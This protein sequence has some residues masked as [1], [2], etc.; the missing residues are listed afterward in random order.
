MEQAGVIPMVNRINQIVASTELACIFK[1]GERPS[2]LGEIDSFLNDPESLVLRISLQ[3][4]SYAFHTREIVANAVGR[5][6]LE[7]ARERRFASQ[8]LIV[9]VDEAH[10]FLNEQL[11]ENTVDYPLDA[12]ALIAKEGRKYSLT[13]CLAT[14]RP[15]DIP[16][17]VLSQMGSF[18]VHRVIN[19][20]DRSV[21]ERAASQADEATM[22]VLPMLSPGEAVMLGIE[23]AIPLHIKMKPPKDKPISS[24]PEYQQY[25]ARGVL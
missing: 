13:L 22:S 15:R 16:E 11:T 17:G 14:Q 18:I 24:G 5:F 8:P 1:P 19:H 25:W 3:H 2:L 4:L 7:Q 12:F 20:N 6:L 10:H 9:F 21:I 23:F